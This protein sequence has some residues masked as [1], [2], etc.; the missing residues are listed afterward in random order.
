MRMREI[1]AR[2]AHDEMIANPAI[3]YVDVR[4][5]EEFHQGH[6]R[7]ALNIPVAMAGM[8]GM[9][10]NPAFLEAASRVLPKGVP[11]IVG[12]KSG[13]RSA[14]ACQMLAQAGFDDLANV[15]GGFLG[16]AGWAPLGL[17]VATTPEPGRGWKDLEPR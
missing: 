6:P 3:V 16:P 11:V 9:R 5:P 2:T 4:T 7:G 1:D 10:A 12:C 8:L 13:Q 15:S 14:M 17:P